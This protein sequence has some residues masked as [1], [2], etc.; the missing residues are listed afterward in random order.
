MAGVSSSDERQRPSA[1]AEWR[2]YWPL[3]LAAMFGYSTIGLQSY[4][5]SPFVTHLEEAFGWTRAQV[6]T[7]LSLSNLAGVFLNIGVGILVD[8]IGPR[9]VG[10]TGLVVK[11][12]AF[13][14]LA[15]ATG[16]LLNWS[17][18]W[19]IL[20]VG[21][22]LLQS[23]IWTRAVA[24]RFDRSRGLAMAVVLSGTP[25]TAMILPVLATFLI[26]AYGWRAAFVGVGFAWLLVTFP[27]VFLLYR[28]RPRHAGAMKE[29]VPPQPRVATGLTV[30]EGIRTRAFLCLL[31]SF[32]AFSFYNMTITASLVPLLAETGISTME[33][34]GIAS[35]MG[36]VG[37]VAR[38][39][40]GFLLD[41]MSGGLIGAITQLLPVLACALLLTGSSDI[42]LLSL[43]VAAFGAATGAEVDVALYLATRHF[44]L[45]SFVTL[46][47]TIITFGALNAAIGPFIGGWLHD[48]YGN[49]DLL[50]MVIMVVMSIGA[51][52]IAFIGKPIRPVS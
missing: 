14:L 19:L 32:G 52:A 16:S 36:I 30:R 29:A 28:D 40:V 42:L 6:M 10:L 11:T 38:L 37:I 41:R 51:A 45:R 27:I 2:S 3:T 8:R 33:A 50:L 48:L 18:L 39:S 31:I 13:A 4:G 26:E 44:G 34:A 24:G 35:L 5:L 47:N 46:F 25:L 12:G 21:V 1:L 17:A 23:S 15:T 43:A 7:G 9:P 20:A 22:V 49:Y